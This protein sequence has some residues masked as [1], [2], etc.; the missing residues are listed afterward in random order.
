MMCLLAYAR[1]L[2][3]NGAPA[4]VAQRK[5]GNRHVCDVFPKGYVRFIAVH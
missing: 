4:P 2:R 3:A 5:V 1:A